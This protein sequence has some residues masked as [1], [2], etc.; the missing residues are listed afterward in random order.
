MEKQKILDGLDIKIID[1]L[2]RNCR[3]SNRKI[4]KVTGV[5]ESTIR[6]RIKRMFDE[7]FIE[8]F[9]LILTEKGKKFYH[10]EK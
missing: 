8:K 7:R 1:L 5:S 10:D 4:A 9:S 2:I 3:I 6:R